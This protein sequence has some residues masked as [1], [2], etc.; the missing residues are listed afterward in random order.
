M[1][2]TK[3]IVRVVSLYLIDGRWHCKN[4][5][6]GSVIKLNVFKLFILL[7][8][9]FTRLAV[10]MVLA[11]LSPYTALLRQAGTDIPGVY[12]D[13]SDASNQQ[14]QFGMD[15]GVKGTVGFVDVDTT[16]ILLTLS[17]INRKDYFMVFS[18][19]FWY[20]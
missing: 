4:S 5:I 9:E 6:D 1:Y 7:Y 3:K 8:S 19:Y 18:I 17:L 2:I 16:G 15:W 10:F 20:S 11:G 13:L 14:T 12:E